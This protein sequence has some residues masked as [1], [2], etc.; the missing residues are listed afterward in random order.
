MGQSRAMN[1]LI[2]LD[3]NPLMR[4]RQ[5]MESLPTL[6]VCHDSSAVVSTVDQFR[7]KRFLDPMV[8]VVHSVHPFKLV[9]CFQRFSD[10]FR[11]LHLRN[12]QF[13]AGVAGFVDFVQ[14]LHELAGQQEAAEQARAVFL[15]V[16]QAHPAILTQRALFFVRQ[17][18]VGTQVVSATMIGQLQGDSL[19]SQS[20]T[21]VRCCGNKA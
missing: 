5:G 9:F 21:V 19:L 1:P 13:E 14:L 3:F 4:D 15:E 10:A 17:A 18:Q 12:Q 7:E 8:D 20:K 6:P 2:L 16:V 11:S